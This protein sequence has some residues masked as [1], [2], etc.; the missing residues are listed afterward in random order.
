[1]SVLGKPGLWRWP[2]AS[3]ICM[4]SSEENLYRPFPVQMILNSNHESAWI[5][6]LK[7][8]TKGTLKL[9]FVPYSEIT[10]LAW[11][12]ARGWFLLSP[13]SPFS[14]PFMLELRGR[15]GK[16]IGVLMWTS[17]PWE[18]PKY[19]LSSVKVYSNWCFL[20]MSFVA[21]RFPDECLVFGNSDALGNRLFLVASWN[22]FLHYQE[23][24]IPSLLSFKVTLLLEKAMENPQTST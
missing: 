6:V 22:N 9:Y 16:E 19:S 3:F 12:R 21:W 2:V 10:F 7:C 5:Q 14:S 8:T 11:W 23:N 24:V 1:M 13:P 15:N 18:L 4:L 17:C 20:W